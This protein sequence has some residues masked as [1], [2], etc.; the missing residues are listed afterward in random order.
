[1]L[2][3]SCALMQPS[4]SRSYSLRGGS[5]MAA[6]LVAAQQQGGWQHNTARAG[7]TLCCGSK[8]C[9]QLLVCR[10]LSVSHVCAAAARRLPAARLLAGGEGPGLADCSAASRLAHVP[11]AP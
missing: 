9:L 4:W 8:L 10:Q 7:C 1:M 6:K 2:Y 3:S 5:N 11:A